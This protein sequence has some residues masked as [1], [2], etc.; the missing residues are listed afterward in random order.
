MPDAEPNLMSVFAEALDRT[1]PATRAAYL[2]SACADDAALRR[3]VAFLR[4]AEAIELDQVFP[5]DPFSQ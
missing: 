3:R 1:V 2:D 4:E 5:A